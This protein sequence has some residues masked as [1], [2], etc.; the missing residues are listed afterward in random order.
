MY[1]T[2][3]RAL[4]IGLILIVASAIIFG[5]SFFGLYNSVSSYHETE[6]APSAIENME[7]NVTSGLLLNYAVSVHSGSS[8]KFVAWFTEPNGDK[9]LTSNFTNT[10]ISKSMV[11]PVSG[12]WFFHLKNDENASTNVSIHLGQISFFLEAGLYGGI[13]VLIVGI[14]MI[15][16]FFNIQKR[17]R[18]RSSP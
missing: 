5:Y 11:A 15:A 10:G 14:V 18:I 2:P 17:E 12:Q 7:I 6:I 16:Y 13:T 3:E 4:K 8:G 9:V 1:V